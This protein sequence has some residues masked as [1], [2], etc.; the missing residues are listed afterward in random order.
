[1]SSTNGGEKM[2]CG[3]CRKE[4]DGDEAYTWLVKGEPANPRFC[5]S[6]CLYEYDSDYKLVEY[7]QVAIHEKKK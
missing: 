7:E 5:S 6:K 1:M 2:K 3:N 4:I